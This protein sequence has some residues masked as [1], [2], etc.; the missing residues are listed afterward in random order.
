LPRVPDF[1]ADCSIYLY[2]SEDAAKKGTRWSIGTNDFIN[3]SII[4]AYNVG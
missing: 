1:I 2:P 3:Q 4:D